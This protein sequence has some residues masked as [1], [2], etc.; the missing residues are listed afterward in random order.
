MPRSIH[1]LDQ[2]RA[3]EVM[4]NNAVAIKASHLAQTETSTS[5]TQGPQGCSRAPVSTVSRRGSGALVALDSCV[6]SGEASS[7][8]S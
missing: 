2:R 1:G 7:A 5:T 3:T 8:V 4:I 6:S